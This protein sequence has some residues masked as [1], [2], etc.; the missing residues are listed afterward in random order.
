MKRLIWM[1]F[2][3]YSFVGYAQTDRK[4]GRMSQLFNFDWKFCYGDMEGA[5]NV[6]YDDSS[7]RK[8]DLPH[9]FQI[10]QPW[11]RSAGGA[12]GFKAM[13]IGW[14]RKT[15]KA[16]TNWKGK[17]VFLDFEGIML[18]G[19]V[20]VNGKSV[21]TADYG[22]LGLETEITR[23]LKYDADNLVAVRASTGET[24][25]S[26]W[27]TGGGLFRDIHLIAKDSVSVASH[28]VFVTTS[29]IS[30][31]HADINVQVEIDG[32][33]VMRKDVIIQAKVISPQGKVVS[34]TESPVPGISRLQKLEVQLPVMNIS[35]PML[36]SCESPALYT[37]E[38]N[39]V[40]DG[41][42]I[43]Q[44]SEPFGIRTIEFSKEFGFKLNGKKVF[45]KGIANH[46]DLGAVGVAAFETS[47]RRQFTQLKKFGYNLVR[48]SHNPYSE[49]FLREADRQGFLIVDELFDKWGGN[50]YW[51][52]RVPF[53]Q[54][55]YKA[56]PEWVKRDRN[57]PSVILW[58]LGNELQ[59]REDLAGFQTSD[60][61]VTTYKIMKVLLNRYDS[62]RST[63]V[64]MFPARANGLMKNEPEFDV[65]VIAPELAT[66]TDVSSFNYRYMNYKQYLQHNPDMNIFQSE[67]ATYELAAPFFG[68]NRDK[69]IG[70]A[71]WGAIEYW[72]ESNGWPKKGWNYSFFDHALN[73]YPQAYLIKSAFVDNPQ[74]YIGVVD[75][76]AD[77][78]EW[79]DVIVGRMPLSSHWNRKSGSIQNLFTYTNADEVELL[80]NGKSLGIKRN[81]KEDIRQRN[82]IYWQDVPYG[83]GG[84]VVAIARNDGKEVARYQL[85]TTGKA[86][87]LKMEPE[88]I[89]W[90]A[91]GMDL[92]YIRIHAIDS[93]GNIVPTATGEIS[94]DVSGEAKLI[95]L[96]N[97]DHYTNELFS[98]SKRSLNRGFAMAVLRSNRAGGKVTVKASLQGLKSA[99]VTFVT[100]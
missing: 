87:A 20:W 95:A 80:V 90:K 96:D 46:H 76:I 64:A 75:S 26:R 69:M 4:E 18:T 45:L 58:S 6:G 29:N 100:K 78:I 62:T 43:D 12:R 99:K 13:G 17:K 48:T 38:I 47:I 54:L 56:I 71:Y 32:P 63:T 81:N 65:Q 92:Q 36:W 5:Q 84:N 66:V 8:L 7:W 50:N 68:M 88:N 53:A 72:G 89:A 93:K 41:N 37:A 40:K 55:W 14:Y 94:L 35:D 57:H 28:G 73:P 9:D 61:G 33:R 85:N 25:N 10:E 1:L 19:E 97:G 70:L 83:D 27:Y 39:L 42:I 86:V 34:E 59:M 22:Y 74:V 98:G 67:A 49:S 77:K 91:D 16:D 44:V 79:N 21:G 52:G 30:E 23:L 24:G 15:F 31:R 51:P 2:L 60:W 11:D 82:M 3:L